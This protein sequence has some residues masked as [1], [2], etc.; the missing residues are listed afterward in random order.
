MKM[1]VD[2]HACVCF[3][4]LPWNMGK[5]V[6]VDLLHTQ[7]KL[8]MMSWRYVVINKCIV[9]LPPYMENGSLGSLQMDTCAQ[10]GKLPCLAHLVLCC[11]A[12]Y[13]FMGP[14]ILKKVFNSP[15]SILNRV[16][17]LMLFALKRVRIEEFQQHSPNQISFKSSPLEKFC[18][19]YITIT[20]Q[21]WL[22]Q[23]LP[24]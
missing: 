1:L 11:S 18:P 16:A 2:K 21:N 3:G 10:G 20:Q 23:F 24:G 14:S 7:P 17:I 9:S 12:W 4:K 5:Y 19:L 22:H 6:T 13:R 8:V 15:V